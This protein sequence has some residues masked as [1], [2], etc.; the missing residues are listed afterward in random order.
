M[1]FTHLYIGVNIS[2]DLLYMI[3]L[4]MKENVC[5]IAEAFSKFRWTTY[6]YPRRHRIVVTHQHL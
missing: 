6:Q 1:V 4:I 5:K 3:T 2:I